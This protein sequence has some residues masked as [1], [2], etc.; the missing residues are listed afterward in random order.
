MR[1]MGFTGVIRGKGI[2]DNLPSAERRQAG[3]SG[4]P[5]L[6]HNQAESAV[7]SRFY[8]CF[9]VGRFRQGRLHHRRVLLNDRRMVGQPLT[10]NR[11]HP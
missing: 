7:G 11:L 10:E 5:G 8:L 9:N 3:G 1:S 6:H 2:S 4:Q